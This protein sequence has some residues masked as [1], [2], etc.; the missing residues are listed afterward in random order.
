MKRRECR[1]PSRESFLFEPQDEIRTAYSAS[2]N[3][4]AISRS[5]C[6]PGIVFTRP[7]R[8]SS[9]RRLISSTQAASAP[10]SAGP[11]SRLSTS[12]SISRP[13]SS[14]E[15]ASA[16]SRTSKTCGVICAII[17]LARTILAA[18][19]RP[20]DFAAINFAVIPSLTGRPISPTFQILEAVRQRLDLDV[21]STP[22]GRVALL[23]QLNRR[24]PPVKLGQQSGFNL[25]QLP[26][27]PL[28][29]IVS[30]H[31]S[32]YKGNGLISHQQ[33]CTRPSPPPAN[34]ARP[35]LSI[36]VVYDRGSP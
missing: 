34:C 31:S 29:V 12:R 21:E 10:S 4:S 27:N 5:T 8:M 6:L 22:G 1:K 9:T 32:K 25:L 13:R 36:R 35:R 7:E 2:G 30:K 3:S 28:L 18:R 14:I 24:G 33:N 11:S 16:L 20:V 23:A 26:P 15:S 19:R 17:H